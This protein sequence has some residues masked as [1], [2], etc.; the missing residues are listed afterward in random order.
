MI[1]EQIR[2]A[3]AEFTPFY[4]VATTSDLQGMCEARAMKIIGGHV[5]IDFMEIMRVSD[6]ILSGIYANVE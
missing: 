1:K 3:I 6:E 5:I 4:E 2:Q